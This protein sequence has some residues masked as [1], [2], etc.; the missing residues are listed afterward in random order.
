MNES[1]VELEQHL[2]LTFAELNDDGIQQKQEI[3][4]F[5][6]PYS[7]SVRE[8]EQSEDLKSAGSPRN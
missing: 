5:E 3:V 6:P 1:E 4:D 2:T 8:I 7:T